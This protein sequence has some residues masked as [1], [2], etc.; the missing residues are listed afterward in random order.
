[1]T[2]RVSENNQQQVP[3]KIS[4]SSGV[5]PRIEG[6]TALRG[7]NRG[8]WNATH[9]TMQRIHRHRSRFH[10]IT[11]PA[12]S[13]R[14]VVDEQTRISSLSGEWWGRTLTG[15]CWY[16]YDTISNARGIHA[17]FD[18]YPRPRRIFCEIPEDFY[19]AILRAAVDKY[20]RKT[21]SIK[22]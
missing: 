13:L 16:H 22:I 3:S 5:V 19:D 8:V 14:S 11:A 1:M 9:A 4:R 20:K 2:T 7:L 15:A 17:T 12:G 6:K 18:I 21:G 10:C